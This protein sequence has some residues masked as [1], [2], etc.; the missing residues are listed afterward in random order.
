MSMNFDKGPYQTIGTGALA[1]LFKQGHQIYPVGDEPAKPS[2]LK[3]L[4]GLVKRGTDFNTNTPC[5]DEMSHI[6]AS[7]GC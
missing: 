6:P 7:D 1:E 3:R 5:G 2:L 4:I